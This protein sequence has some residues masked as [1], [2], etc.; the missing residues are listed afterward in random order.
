MVPFLRSCVW[1]LVVTLVACDPPQIEPVQLPPAT[2]EKPTETEPSILQPTP[3]EPPAAQHETDASPEPLP[4]LKKNPGAIVY[5]RKRIS[6]TNETGI[7]G[8]APGTAVEVVAAL[9]NRIRVKNS[10]GVE[11]EATE[12]FFTNSH[13]EISAIHEIQMA[14]QK[15]MAQKALLAKEAEAAR[16]AET[17]KLS[18]EHAAKLKS[19]R[20]RKLEAQIAALKSR[21]DAAESELAEKSR[22]GYYYADHWNGYR[23]VYRTRRAG[24]TL[25][26]DASQIDKLWDQHRAMIN[27]LR[28]LRGAD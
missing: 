9:D 8:I 15:T 16:A 12:D 28:A 17:K 7:Y 1:V 6:I 25:S 11:L 18:I 13:E 4:R 5:V 2:Q 20:I 22:R 24:G 23:W 3:V 26:P 21:I 10:E 19:E 27:R 14:T